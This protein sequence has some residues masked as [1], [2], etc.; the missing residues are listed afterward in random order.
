MAALGDP[1]WAGTTSIVLC[2]RRL[3]KQTAS[4]FLIIWEVQL[5]LETSSDVWSFSQERLGYS[6]RWQGLGS[7]SGGGG[8]GG[9]PS[10]LSGAQ[11]RG[12]LQK[13]GTLS[14]SGKQHLHVERLQA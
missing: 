11:L 14:P 1:S 10:L 7:S 12:K 8:G 5:I 3:Q 6:F 13:A 2:K 4:L 9:C